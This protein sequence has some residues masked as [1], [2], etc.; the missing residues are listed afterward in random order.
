[1]TD[2]FT[3]P[4]GTK[5]SISTNLNDFERVYNEFGM[6][7]MLE[8]KEDSQK[9]RA[10]FVREHG[11][12]SS[13]YNNRTF[14]PEFRMDPSEIIPANRS[15]QIEEAHQLCHEY[16]ECR[17][18]YAMSLNRD[19]AHFTH[20]Y[21]STIINY[22]EVSN[23]RVISCGVLETPRFGRKSNFLFIPG[24]KVTFECNQDFILVGDQRRECMQNGQW[25]VP[26]YGY[27]ECL[28]K[29]KLT[30]TFLRLTLLLTLLSF[31]CYVIRSARIFISTSWHNVWDNS[32]RYCTN[33]YD[34]RVRCFRYS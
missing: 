30:N 18:D 14:K 20:N 25:D 8:D 5:I 11:R 2:D 9:G 29:Y 34:T 28:R 19:L 32:R 23:E 33:Y 21:K 12:T 10:L 7:W 17:Y 24:T 15:I 1:M 26:V 31:I 16:Y 27:T 3:N 6:N 22:R 4:D 13:T